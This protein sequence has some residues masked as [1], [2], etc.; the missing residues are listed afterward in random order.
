MSKAK[1][2]CAWVTVQGHL[3]IV[4]V[5]VIAKVTCIIVTENSNISI[6]AIAKASEE[7]IPIFT[8]CLSSYEVAKL[9][10]SQGL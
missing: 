7:N 3:N 9:L 8:T 5:A 6:D 4:A 10:A 2:G 1:E